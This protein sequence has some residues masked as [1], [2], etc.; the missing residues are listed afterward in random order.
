MSMKNFNIV[1]FLRSNRHNQKLFN[2]LQTPTFKDFDL[3]YF[4]IT[5]LKKISKLE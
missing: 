1:Q 3:T 4:Q 5:T 2:G